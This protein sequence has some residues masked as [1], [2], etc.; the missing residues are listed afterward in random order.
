VKEEDLTI[1][2]KTVK[3]DKDQIIDQNKLKTLTIKNLNLIHHYKKML[4]SG[5]S[6]EKKLKSSKMMVSQLLVSQSQKLQNKKN[7]MKIIM[8]ERIIIIK[9]KIKI[10]QQLKL[11][12]LYIHEKTTPIFYLFNRFL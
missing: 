3:E 8:E 4:K 9:T 7:G 11:T 12:D 6:K 1:T 5:I 2:T 10:R